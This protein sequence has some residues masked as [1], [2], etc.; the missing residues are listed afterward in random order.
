[1]TREDPF[2]M[3]HQRLAL[4]SGGKV[5]VL[6]I[7]VLSQPGISGGGVGIQYRSDLP[8]NDLTARCAEARE[9]VEC[10]RELVDVDAHS[11]SA[12][13]CN[14]L[15]AAA[16]REPPEHTFLFTRD[17]EGRWQLQAS[18]G[19]EGQSLDSPP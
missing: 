9:L 8:A 11:I 18:L 7:V 2:P 16:M 14:T 12:Q 19:P 6:N 1:M 15:A 3:L 5:T 4:P 17:T 10:H 13:V